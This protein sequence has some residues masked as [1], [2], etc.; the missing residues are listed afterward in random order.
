[1]ERSTNFWEDDHWSSLFAHLRLVKV[2]GIS[3]IKSEMDFIKFLLSNS[4]VLE[5]LT[6]KPASQEGKWELMKE[7]LRFRR[8]S[9]YAE[10][11]HCGKFRV[12]GKWHPWQVCFFTSFSGELLYMQKSFICT[13]VGF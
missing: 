6:V 11:C 3:G 5:Q 10:V 9:I 12:L 2:S 7:L 4:P 1:M 13:N 8:A